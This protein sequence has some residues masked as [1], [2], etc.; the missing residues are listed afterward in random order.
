MLA[1]YTHAH[2][3]VRPSIHLS[4]QEGFWLLRWAAPQAETSFSFQQILL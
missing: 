3:S 2:L 4:I 1:P